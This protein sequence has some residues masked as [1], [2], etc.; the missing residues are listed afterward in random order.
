MTTIKK[1][2]EALETGVDSPANLSVPVSV[3]D[4]ILADQKAKRENLVKLA[5]P[6]IIDAENFFIDNNPNGVMYKATAIRLSE[7]MPAELLQEW[8]LAL[9]KLRERAPLKFKAISYG[10]AETPVF[11]LNF[12]EYGSIEPYRFPAVDNTLGFIRGVGSRQM[13]C[14]ITLA[15]IYNQIKG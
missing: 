6:L 13:V 1:G 11:Y 5:A 9:E 15:D 8:D 12:G 14:K 3:I 4:M 10:K 2:A 7:E